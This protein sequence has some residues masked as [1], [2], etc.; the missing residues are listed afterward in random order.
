MDGANGSTTFTDESGKTWTANGD[1]KISTEQFVFGGASGSFA[2]TGYLSTPDSDDFFYSTNPFT[3]D[4]R[5]RFVSLPIAS[6]YQM[7]FSQ[8]VSDSDRQLMGLYNSSG[9]LQWV[10][11]S[12]ATGIIF[13][14]SLSINTWYHIAL[15]RNGNDWYLF[16]D[17]TQVGGTQTSSVSVDNVAAEFQIGKYQ[18]LYY[19]IYGYIDEFR[20]S[21]GVARWTSNF[22]PPTLPYG[23]G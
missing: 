11:G 16:Q 8:W 3:I 9:T 17:G 2:G 22:T 6:D 4:F 12:D 20:I 21:K 18:G 1:A 5:V 13:N 23:G 15:V 7:I 19:H 10:F 14:T